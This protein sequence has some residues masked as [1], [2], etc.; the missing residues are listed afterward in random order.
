MIKSIVICVVS[1]IAAHYAI[2]YINRT[3]ANKQ[4]GDAAYWRQ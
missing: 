3:I 2:V 1:A 4:Q